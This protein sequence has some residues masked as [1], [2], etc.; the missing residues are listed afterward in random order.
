MRSRRARAASLLVAVSIA[1]STETDPAARIVDVA[2]E[3]LVVDDDAAN[4]LRLTIAYEDPDGDLGEGEL[5]VFDCRSA[6]ASR[7]L[8]IPGIT[9]DPEPG[10]TIT[11]ELEVVVPDIG[12][13]A[14]GEAPPDPCAKEGAGE[15]VFCFVLRDRAGN[16]SDVV[17]TDPIPIAP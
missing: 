2:S 12:D 15:G 11:G 17:C 14:A 9:V 3:L 13:V 10:V 16:E 5:L 1:C 7:S 4:D 6:R 8:P